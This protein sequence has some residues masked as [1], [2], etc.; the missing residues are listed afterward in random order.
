MDI[1]YTIHDEFDKVFDEKGN[2]FLAL[3]KI[4]W[5]EKSQPKF[6]LRKWYIGKDG[7]ETV[8]KGFSFLT[9]EGPHDLTHV[10]LESGFGNTKKIIDNIKD[11][12]D[13]NSAL[14][15]SIG[16]EELAN[17]GLE[18]IES[19]PEEDDNLYDPKVIFD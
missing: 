14:I 5:G 15:S 17:N 9:E 2:T 18:Y 1:K 11:R 19:D 12:D 6:D 8:G 4:S 10:L 3:R 13:F 7:I 16:K